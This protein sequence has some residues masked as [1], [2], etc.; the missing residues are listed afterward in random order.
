MDWLPPRTG[1]GWRRS[2]NHQ[3]AISFHSSKPEHCLPEP[4][5][6]TELCIPLRA[7]I[8]RSP[9][10][11]WTGSSR[12]SQSRSCCLCTAPWL[13]GWFPWCCSHPA[14]PQSHQLWSASQCRQSVSPA[15]I[16]QHN[17]WQ[18][19]SH[20]SATSVHCATVTQEKMS[21]IAWKHRNYRRMIISMY[22]RMIISSYCCSAIRSEKCWSF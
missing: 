21:N 17:R 1:M 13:W 18:R 4:T 14:C 12:V 5:P 11:S 2:I 22:R 15:S 16:C 3:S 8:C 7:Q 10:Q 9:A 6:W 19:P 20:N